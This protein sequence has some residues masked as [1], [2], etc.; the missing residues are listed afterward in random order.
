V[1][2]GDLTR[3]GVVG[4]LKTEKARPELRVFDND[5]VEDAK[6]DRGD[7][8]V[9]ALTMLRAYHVAG[10]PGKPRPALGSFEH[11]SNTVRG[12]LIW[13][14]CGDPVRTQ[15]RLREKDPVLM[16]L[17]TVLTA[18][19]D[20]YGEDNPIVANRAAKDANATNP[21]P[22]PGTFKY[23]DEIVHPELHN[24]L[25]E[26]AGRR[27]E[28]DARVL[29]HWLEKHADRPVE[30]VELGVKTLVRFR[31]AGKLHGIQQWAVA[32]VR[33]G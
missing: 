20:M 7:L 11:W 3:R 23:V 29:G 1:V 16:E 19:R 24:A 4:R 2:K 32:P 22:V 12:T 14:G 27:G 31:S 30:L 6:R 17:V 18:W 25:M 33:G 21:K 8:V 15:D 28:V 5:P 9:A 26:V 10:C 13:L